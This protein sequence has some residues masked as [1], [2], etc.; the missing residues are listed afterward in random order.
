M[1]KADG[2]IVDRLLPLCRSLCKATK[3]GKAA[4]LDRVPA[5]LIKFA[6]ESFVLALT[7]FTADCLSIAYFPNAVTDGAL[8]FIPKPKKD[9]WRG[10][11]VSS[12]L[13]KIVERLVGDDIFPSAKDQHSDA[14]CQEQFA[15]T[16]RHSAEMAA[17]ILELI[18]QERKDKPTYLLFTDVAAAY[19]NQWRE[20]LWFKLLQQYSL[21]QVK[22][23]AALYNKMRSFI[24]AGNELSNV[25]DC[26]KGLGQGSPN[27]GNLFCAYIA[28]LPEVLRGEIPSMNLYGAAITC[29]IFMDDLV[30]PLGSQ[31]QVRD[32][33]QIVYKYSRKWALQFSPEKTRVLCFNVTDPPSTWDFGPTQIPTARSETCLSVTFSDDRMWFE[34]FNTKIKKTEKAY[35]NLRGLGL[36]GGQQPVNAVSALIQAKLWPKLDIGRAVTDISAPV[37]KTLRNT[38]L[39]LQIRIGREILGLSKRSRL[40]A[41]IGELGWIADHSRAELLSLRLL[42]SFATSPEGSLPMRVYNMISSLPVQYQ[43][44]FFSQSHRVLHN[45][46]CGTPRDCSKQ[47]LKRKF[48]ERA[49]ESW[50]ERVSTHPRLG[51]AYSNLSRLQ[52][53]PYLCIGNF[54][55]RRLF[56]KLRADDLALAAAAYNTKQ[57]GLCPLCRADL[58][59]R[60][61]FLFICPALQE[62]RQTY[63][64]KV[65]CLSTNVSI[66]NKLADF[67]QPKVTENHKMW[68]IGNFLADLW[69]KRGSLL[70][71]ARFYRYGP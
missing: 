52:I 56:T 47:L 20:A 5:E 16:K 42:R 63:Q 21:Q 58:E 26:M 8:S 7:I 66:E 64:Q 32:A 49:S 67:L 29:L 25:I 6:P 17:M 62:V 9:A 68:N 37:Y 50:L 15:G 12:I 11:R 19:D 54:R 14:I 24:K 70:P 18:L 4:G 33:L 36:V 2:K 59:S 48:M 27:S 34:H 43:P 53:Q 39:K 60:E 46:G 10:I 69:V 13:G 31:Q 55:G 44:K 40:D 65:P 71:H 28:D 57:P 1:R 61:H 41:V 22:Q 35:N 51:P 30:I 45:I 23:I 3:S 38:L